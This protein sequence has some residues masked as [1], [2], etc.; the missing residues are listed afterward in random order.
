MA[1]F[2]SDLRYAAR[3]LLRNPGFTAVAVV[4]LAL[5]I[6]ANTAIFSVVDGVLLR[7][8]PVEDVDRLIMVWETDRNS[9]TTREPASFPDYIDFRERS[10]RLTDLAAFMGREVNHTPPQGDS[11]RLA[12]LAVTRLLPDAR[13]PPPR[14]TRVQ[15]RRN[16]SRWTARGHDQRGPLD[17]SLRARRRQRR[18]NRAVGRSGGDRDWGDAERIGLRRVS[19]PLDRRVRAVV[20]R[21]RLTGR[22]RRLATAPGRRGLASPLDSS[23][24]GRRPARLRGESG[25]RPGRARCHRG[26]PRARLSGERRSRRVRRA[27]LDGGLRTDP[28]GPAGLA[29]CRHARAARGLHQRR[30]P[31]AGA[32]RRAKKRKWRCVWRSARGRLDSHASFSSTVSS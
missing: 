32:R 29:R 28:S 20:C 14:G 15:R 18:T 7:P 12:A 31:V 6:G 3:T 9:G 22:R 27:A 11:V 21:P 25:D 2:L 26:R 16:E 17:P 19:D 13:H 8:A 4:T 5:G 10:A 23:D 1:E 24:P 30:Q